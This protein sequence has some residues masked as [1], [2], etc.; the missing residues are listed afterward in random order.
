MTPAGWEC[1]RAAL[2]MISL[3]SYLLDLDAV[4][5]QLDIQ[6]VVLMG[7]HGSALLAGH[8]AARHPER[9]EALILCNTGVCWQGADIAH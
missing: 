7:S 8:Y 1:R 4:L 2:V 5:E 9:V 6:R 3:D